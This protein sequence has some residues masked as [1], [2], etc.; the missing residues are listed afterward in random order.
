M[1]TEF[2]FR[3]GGMIFFGILGA[4]LGYQLGGDNLTP[5][6][7]RLA[8]IVGLISG[9]LLMLVSLFVY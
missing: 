5:E 4:L 7:I 9:I 1:S 8:L 3:I 6:A 2:Y